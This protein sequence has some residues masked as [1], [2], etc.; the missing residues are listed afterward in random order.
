MVPCEIFIQFVLPSCELYTIVYVYSICEAISRSA[1]IFKISKSNLGSGDRENYELS[2][3][4]NEHLITS[5]QPKAH[6]ITML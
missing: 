3:I 4:A 1:I 2:Y 6:Y 5:K